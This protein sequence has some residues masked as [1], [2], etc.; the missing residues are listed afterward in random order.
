MLVAALFVVITAVIVGALVVVAVR[1][2]NKVKVNYERSN[3]VVP[4]VPSPAPTSWLGSHDAEARLHRRLVDVMKALRAN[5][6]FDQ[7]GILLDLRVELEQQAVAIDA[8]L[9]ATAALPLSMREAP[10][11]S[12]AGAVETLETA[13]AGLATKSAAEVGDRL[14]AVL[15]DLQLRTST[16][17][18]ARAALDEIDAATNAESR[19]APT[20]PGPS[21]TTDPDEAPGSTSEGSPG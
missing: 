11:Q 2:A 18:Q 16:V 4:G 21:T 5:Q 17:A 8:E 14:Q 6:S 12:L 13:V 19:S 9:V 3:D 10:L 1:T 15:D 7:D 20:D